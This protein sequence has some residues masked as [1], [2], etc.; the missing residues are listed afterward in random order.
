MSVIKSHV[1]VDG[2][3]KIVKKNHNRISFSKELESVADLVFLVPFDDLP[4]LLDSTIEEVTFFANA[5]LK[6]THLKRVDIE[7]EAEPPIPP[8]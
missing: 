6:F 2:K 7:I 5:R 1:I 8:F 4:L 3:L